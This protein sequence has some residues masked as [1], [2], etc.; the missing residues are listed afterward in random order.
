[1]RWRGGRES[2]NVEDNR[3]GSG[4]KVALGG[5]IGAIIIV[6]ISLITGK[7][8]SGILQFL[9]GGNQFTQ[10][11]P[12]SPGA[13][14]STSQMVRV[15]LGSTE[16]VWSKIFQDGGSTYTEPALRMFTH[17]EQS[18]CGGAAAEM[19]PFY[20]PADQ[21]IYIDLSFC[22]EL[23]TRF[24][25]PGNFAIAYV[26]AH[27]VGHHVQNLLGISEQVQKMRGRLSEADYNKLSVK[28]ELQADFLA[29]V[30]AYH[31][32]QTTGMI[33]PGDLETALSAASAI[34]DDKLQQ[35]AQGYVVPDAFTHGTSKQRMYWFKK[36][37]TTGDMSQGKFEN[38]N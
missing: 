4:K 29:G 1:M 15:V 12:L 5:G 11:Q 30:W 25:T 6:I 16:D 17:S 3:G 38:I 22:N 32:R 27:E 19:G 20:C 36:G 35:E 26:V 2:T 28:L 31:E 34:G 10:S 24:K 23:R 18:A 13:N 9:D 33:E 8:L 21:K 37:F 7:D 14:D